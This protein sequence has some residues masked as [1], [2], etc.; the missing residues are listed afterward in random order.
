MFPQETGWNTHSKAP[1]CD[2]GRPGHEL[3]AMIDEIANMV[4]QDS[5]PV[6]HVVAE[7]NNI[8][9]TGVNFDGYFENSPR[10]RCLACEWE[11]IQI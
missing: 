3:D 11:S 7:V 8:A 6:Q 2:V 1:L 5:W 10:R 4:D 9:S